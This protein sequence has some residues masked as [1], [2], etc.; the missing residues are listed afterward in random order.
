[1]SDNY[2]RIE[3]DWERTIVVG[4]IHGCFDELKE[5]LRRVEFRPADLLISTGDMVDRGPDTWRVCEFFRDT[6]N[7]FA[8]L[9]NHE[10]RLAGT[11]RGTSRPAWSQKHTLSKIAHQEW[12]PWLEFL[13]SLPAVVETPHVIVTHARLDPARSVETQDP[14]HTCAVG[15]HRVKI[16][17]DNQG[18]PGWFHAMGLAKVICIGHISYDRVELV[19]GRFFALDTGAVR[20]YDLTC[21]IFPERRILS[22][23]ASRNYY[24]E[25]RE[26]W[27][28]QESFSSGDV[29][30]SLL[31]NVIALLGSDEQLEDKTARALAGDLRSWIEGLC[32]P[33]WICETRQC[34]V[35]H[36][37]DVP[38]P[39]PQ[40]GVYYD[41]VKNYFQ[42]RQLGTLA[43][44]VLG[45]KIQSMEAFA[46]IVGIDSL[47][48]VQRAMDRLTAALS[49]I[50]G[51]N[52]GTTRGQPFV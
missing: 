48:S 29:S 13:D 4:D 15:G 30:L 45:H 41:R 21:A 3:G 40:R 38:A 46:K 17:L 16:E 51:H 14:Y 36:F 12:E 10:R 44:R 1:M 22:V 52:E 5:L 43:R 8:V 35:D 7:A 18:V 32:L 34:L 42:D 31:S 20:G 27:R 11:I 28:E 50:D 2:R 49:M 6:V 23:K 37:G 26:R 19:P 47:A 24:A 33:Q 25:S 39:G 9:G